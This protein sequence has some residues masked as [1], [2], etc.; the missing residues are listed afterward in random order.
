MENVEFLLPALFK[1]H[2]PSLERMDILGGTCNSITC[3][4]LGIFPSLAFLQIN[5]LEVLESL[6]FMIF[7]EGVPPPSLKGLSIYG[8]PSLVSVELPAL[9]FFRF[10]VC[11]CKQLKSLLHNTAS[12]R[13]LD[14]QHCPKLIF[15]IQCLPTGLT[16]LTI[17]N[18]KKLTSRLEVASLPALIHLDIDGRFAKRNKTLN[19][20]FCRCQRSL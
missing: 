12:C 3:F 8:C 19:A 1:C 4:P 13:S 17:R 5:S 18:C 10:T 11:N 6:S 16:S 14:L 15:P 9:N 7:D 2:F 20:Q